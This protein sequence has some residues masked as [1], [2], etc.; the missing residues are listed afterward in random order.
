MFRF[1]EI[2]SLTGSTVEECDL[3]TSVSSPHLHLIRL[4]KGT[5][6]QDHHHLVELCVSFHASLMLVYCIHQAVLMK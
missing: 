6:Q 2:L 1:L 4:M 5:I 3:L